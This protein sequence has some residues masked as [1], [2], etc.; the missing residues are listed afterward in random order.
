MPI[1]SYW[2]GGEVPG[3]LSGLHWVLVDAWAQARVDHL[4]LGHSGQDG[5]PG[6]GF[7]QVTS[8]MVNGRR[9]FRSGR[10]HDAEPHLFEMV[11]RPAPDRH[12]WLLM[13]A[14]CAAEGDS[15]VEAAR[16]LGAVEATQE[17]FGLPWLPRFLVAARDETERAGREATG[18]ETFAAARA[19]GRRL[20]LDDAVAYALRAR[21]ERK[22]PSSGWA[23][24][25]PTE[26]QVVEQVAAGRSNTEIAQQLLMGP[27]T[28]KTHLAHIFTK[29][30][31][32]NRAELAAEATRRASSHPN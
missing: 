18:Q 2:F 8:H 1:P 9:A 12:F 23:S 31:M 13:L 5:Q 26:R 22:R 24:L 4:G 25:T 30:G 7:Q 10:F 28:V 32:T 20:D 14:R 17:R 6:P 11:R 15:H 29:L 21:G 3:L 19:E 16:L 27:T